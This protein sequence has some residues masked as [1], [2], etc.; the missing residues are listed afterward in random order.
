MQ[1]DNKSLILRGYSIFRALSLIGMNTVTVLLSTYNGGKFLC[2]QLESLFAQTGVRVN[3]LVRDDGSKDNTLD[4]LRKYESQP[5]FSWYSGQNKGW[6]M[7]FMD[8]VSK[9]P[10]SD[11]YAFCDQDDVWKPCKLSR[12]IERINE[13]GKENV[14]YFSNL[15]S[16]RHGM[17]EGNVKG[18]FSFNRFTSLVM[19]QAYGCTMVFDRVLMMIIKNHMP[20]YVAAH[21][22]WVYL[23][24]SFLSTVIY[25][26]ESYILYRQ[27]SSNQIGAQSN[28][29]AVLK[30]RLN[31]L[32]RPYSC[33][34]HD[35]QAQAFLES[36]DDL[37]CDEDKSA[38]A[39]VADYRNSLKNKLALLKDKRI[40]TGIRKKDLIFD[41]KIL[42]SLI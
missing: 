24:A 16:W 8:L 1:S 31:T 2:E 18:E 33:F 32:F 13:T 23:T 38:I 22:Y 5:R 41:A 9:A 29:F 7:S 25:E 40:C 37:L 3:I 21:D 35:F 36:Y 11:Y 17:E 34:R 14:L 20:G 26:K 15:T 28:A 19:C 12:A 27:H 10:D 39:L 6:A 30:R 42:L 4:I